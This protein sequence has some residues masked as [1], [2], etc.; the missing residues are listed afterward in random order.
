MYKT[1]LSFSILFICACISLF[2]IAPV[3][4]RGFITVAISD[5]IIGILLIYG[6]FINRSYSKSPISYFVL[7][8]VLS[9]YISGLVNVLTDHTF[10]PKNFLTNY[11]R[12]VGLLGMV[13]L[14]P[15]FLNKIG[16]KQIA[17]STL[18]ILRI[19]V[20]LIFL[21]AYFVNPFTFVG[22]KIALAESGIDYHRP[23]GMFAEP[24]FFGIYAGLSSLYILQVE[25]N[26]NHI[27]F[28]FVDILMIILSLIISTSVSSIAFMLLFLIEILRYRKLRFNT[29]SLLVIS[30]TLVFVLSSS[31]QTA[32]SA[33]LNAKY[34][35]EK[36]GQLRLGAKDENIR[37]RILGG[38]I[39]ASKIIEESPF[40]GI[41]LGGKNQDRV[42]RRMD[43]LYA[44]GTSSEEM[45]F[46]P[47]SVMPISVVVSTGLIGLVFYLLV[48]FSVVFKVKSRLVGKSLVAVFFMWGNAF[49]PI[50]WW[51]V[52]LG[53]SMSNKKLNTIN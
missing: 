1:K 18:W 41:G 21:D 33:G 29:L 12:I 2:S 28:T 30:S 52:S 23:R 13:F 10:F 49:A 5:I 51:Y 31:F 3:S 48:F 40:L 53:I 20:A 6:F 34:I 46:G 36:V 44:D 26:L 19:H 17:K 32:K 47:G 14:L 25:K 42:L 9:T 16:H 15:S 35:I 27:I 24:S 22:S 4:I 37:V 7:A 8:F 45:A 11:I 39:F 43:I 38:F 50:V